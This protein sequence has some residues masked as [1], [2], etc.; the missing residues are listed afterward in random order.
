[1]PEGP[2]ARYLAELRREFRGNPLL[3]RRVLEEVADHLADAAA[4]AR[5]SGMS[6]HDAEAAAVERFGPAPRFSRQFDRFALPLRAILA[7]ASLATAGMAVWLFYVIAFVLPARDPAHVPMWLGMAIAYLAWAALSWAFLVAGPRHAVL[8]IAG[9]L[10][11]A[12]AMAWGLALVAGGLRAAHFEGYL[13]LMGAVL[14]V[15]GLAA[16]AYLLLT[17][18]IARRLRAS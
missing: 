14:V 1:M 13:L 12:L 17:F 3:A 6:D 7:L 16:I 5:E 8:R 11:A 2:V 9:P 10:G 18:G 4:A 15:H